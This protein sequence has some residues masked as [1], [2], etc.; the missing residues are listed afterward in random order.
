M[1]HSISL[2][3]DGVLAVYE[4]DDYKKQ[5]YAFE[6]PGSHYFAKRTVDT[7]MCDVARRLEH[8]TH[9]PSCGLDLFIVSMASANGRLFAE[10]S[11]DK[12]A[13]LD[14]YVKDGISQHAVILP[15]SAYIKA[16]KA[17]AIAARLN[18]PLDVCD[19]LLDDYNPHLTAWT[20]MGGTAMKY[21]NGINSGESWDGPCI[22]KDMNP[23]DIVSMLQR[24]V[25]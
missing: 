20:L 16:H 15:H 14:K 10:Q 5:P 13:W 6:M 25:M 19:V 18:R 22:T 17:R 7:V 3:M 9:E 24:I 23:R 12:V 2:D 8:L 4:P 11:A 1:N 21:L